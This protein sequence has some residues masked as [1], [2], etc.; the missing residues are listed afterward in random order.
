M[1]VLYTD[2][3]SIWNP[4]PWWWWS[5]FVDDTWKKIADRSWSAKETTNNRMELEA[6]VQWLQHV[7]KHLIGQPM[8][9]DA[10]WCQ[11]EGLFRKEHID[12]NEP[13]SDKIRIVTD[14]TYVQKWITDRIVKRKKNNWK[15]AS[16]QPVKN[17][18][19]RMQL[20]AV[21]SNFRLLERKRTKWHA[22]HKANEYVDMLARNAAKAIM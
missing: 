21:V 7:Y 16:R 20:D 1:Y 12:L 9:I 3:S 18:D 19:L 17:Q 8:N 22:W 10:R 2:G 4:W 6:V 5:L 14:S 11:T 15:T 13:C